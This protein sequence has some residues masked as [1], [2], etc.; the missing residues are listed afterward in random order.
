MCFL[1]IQYFLDY[2]ADVGTRFSWTSADNQ[3]RP[4]NFNPTG[5]VTVFWSAKSKEK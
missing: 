2:P 1:G 3:K 4:V 5:N